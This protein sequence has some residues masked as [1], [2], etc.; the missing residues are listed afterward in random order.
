METTKKRTGTT[1]RLNRNKKHLPIVTADT[2]Q[3]V[4]AEMQA[5]KDKLFR[6]MATG[7]PTH[8]GFV[9][10]A[11]KLESITKDALFGLVIGVYAM[12]ERELQNG[13]GS[14]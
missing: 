2:I 7:N 13:R 12:L 10:N 3:A 6:E 14:G 11:Y 4:I 5:D 9:Y 8:Y 1:R